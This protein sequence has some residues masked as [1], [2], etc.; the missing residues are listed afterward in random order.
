[1]GDP[2]L[3]SRLLSAVTGRKISEEE[4]DLIGSRVFELNRAIMIRDGRKGREEDVLSDSCFVSMKEPPADIFDMYNPER[5]LPGKGEE[6][7]SLKDAAV[8]REKFEKLMDEYYELRGWDVEPGCLKKEQLTKL[9]LA[10]VI[11]ELGD[12]VL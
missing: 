2:S 10:E 6:L 1:V 11:D 4:L 8:D 9:Q 12:K 7:I 3:E 5:Y